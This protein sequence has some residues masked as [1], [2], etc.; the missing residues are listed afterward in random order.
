MKKKVHNYEVFTI[1]GFK[2]K[3]VRVQLAFQQH[4]VCTT[5]KRQVMMNPKISTIPTV[6][7]KHTTRLIRRNSSLGERH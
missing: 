2:S 6:V 5:V 4:M 7:G 1:I 3:S